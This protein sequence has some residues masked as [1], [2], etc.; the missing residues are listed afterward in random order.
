MKPTKE[1]YIDLYDKLERIVEAACDVNECS[2][3]PLKENGVCIKMGVE[4][5]F[6][7]LINRHFELEEKYKILTENNLFRDECV[8]ALNDLSGVLA[9]R[10]NDKQETKEHINTLKEL[11]EAI[12]WQ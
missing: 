5:G 2:T 1:N 12:F 3:C 10:Q 11:I 9:T 4:V 6:E 8:E 7:N